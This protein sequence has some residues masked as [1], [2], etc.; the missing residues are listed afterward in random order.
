M[1]KTVLI[2]HNFDVMTGEAG[3]GFELVALTKSLEQL[4]GT[5]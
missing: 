4:Q 2:T 3:N 1:M 5:Y